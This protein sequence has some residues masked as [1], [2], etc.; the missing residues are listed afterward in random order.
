MRLRT[1]LVALAAAGSVLAAA[2]AAMPVHADASADVVVAGREPSCG[3]TSATGFPIRTRIRGGPATYRPG[4]GFRIWHVELTNTTAQACRNIHPVIILSDRGHA[5]TPA[6]V[7]MDFADGDEVRKRRAVRVEVTDEH[8]IVGVLDDD[9][10]PA[11]AGFTV[12]AGGTVAVP[13]RLAFAADALPDELAVTAAIVQRRGHDGDW[14]GE[15]G[16]YR[17]TLAATPRSGEQ[18]HDQDQGHDQG[19]D[20]SRDQS[21]EQ[22]GDRTSDQTVDRPGGVLGELARTG[23]RL[24]DILPIA[25]AAVGCVVLGAGALLLARA[26]RR[27]P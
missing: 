6:Q 13:V 10:D 18:G 1:A 12:P 24:A 16:V 23:R 15:S 20:Q 14:V 21:R 5:L 8:E 19:H 4:G 25:A 9:T 22:S 3:D 11:F 26:R 2:L 27:R 7:R 17:F